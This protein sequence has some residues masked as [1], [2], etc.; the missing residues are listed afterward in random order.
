MKNIV[1]QIA[2]LLSMVIGLSLN[3][4]EEFAVVVTP[5]LDLGD[6]P[7][8]TI[9]SSGKA[10]DKFALDGGKKNPL[11]GCPR[12]HQLIYHEIVK[13]QKKRGDLYEINVP[14]MFYVTPQSVTPRSDSLVKKQHFITFTELKR[15]KVDITKFPDPVSYDKKN[16]SYDASN[17][18][19]CMPYTE[20]HTKMTFSA[21]TRFKKVEKDDEEQNE[22][23]SVYVFDKNVFSFIT[24]E[25]P[26]NKLMLKPLRTVQDKIK[27]FVQLVRS[28]A[29]L[30]SGFIPYVWGG[31]TFTHVSNGSFTEVL[32]T[33]EKT[34]TSF[35]E[36]S[37]FPYY[38]RPGFDCSGLILR[39]AQ[40]CQIPYF[41]KNSTTIAQYLNELKNDSLQDGD[42]IVIPRHVMLVS[43]VKNNLLVEARSYTHGYGKVQELPLKKVFQGINTYDDLIKAYRNER[44]IFRLNSD[45]VIAE[46]I[47]Q[48]K[49]V[50]IASTWDQ[51]PL[52]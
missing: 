17:V 43:S 50:K 40:I 4:R 16:E 6:S 27:A 29:S 22:K 12:M 52:F 18:T 8:L 7:S 47:P 48:I 44:S 45:N 30:D 23:I 35:F 28:W 2:Y 32:A 13:I 19:L 25:I 51:K 46:I 5:I 34:P 21:G 37:D 1:K 31:S 15:K 20:P 36:L 39:A 41:F 49:L 9:Q 24:A 26:R 11:T 38:P 42:L 10:Y 3:A 33:Q 14:N